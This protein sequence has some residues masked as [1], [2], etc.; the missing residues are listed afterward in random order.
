MV[1]GGG[2]EPPWNC[3]RR[4]LSPLRLPVPPSRR[5]EWTR[6]AYVT[7]PCEILELGPRKHFVR[8]LVSHSPRQTRSLRLIHLAKATPPRGHRSSLHTS[9]AKPAST[10]HRRTRTPAIF[11]EALDK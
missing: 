11:S 3:F 4:I 5:Y 2:I 6:S 7:A 9:P 8:L 10:L 1:P